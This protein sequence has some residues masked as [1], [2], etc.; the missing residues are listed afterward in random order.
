MKKKPLLAAFLFLIIGASTTW[1]TIS[2][3]IDQVPRAEGGLDKKAAILLSQLLPGAGQTKKREAIAE[4]TKRKDKRF[5]APL[6]D[7]LRYQRIRDDYRLVARALLDLTDIKADR[8]ESFWEQMVIWVAERP[9]LKTPPGYVAWKGKLHAAEIDPR[10]TEFLYEGVEIEKG[11]R[12]EEVVWGGVRVD[13]IPALVNPK[14]LAAEK[15]DYILDSEPV[16]GVSINGDNRAYP[17][18]I[19][20]W[21][22]MA[23]DVVGG[24]QVALA[25]CTLCGAGILFDAELEGGK[26]QFGSSGYLMRSNKLMYD[27][28]TKTL[29]NQLTGKP[30]IGKLVGKNLELKVLPLVLTSWGEWKAQHKNTKVLSLETGYRR[31]YQIGATYGRYFASPNT[32]FPVRKKI[33]KL[34]RK[35]RIY[36]IQSGGLAKAYPLDELNKAGGVVND[37]VGQKNL[38]VVYK[39]AVG[40]VK[41]SDDIRAALK[42][43][44]SSYRFEYANELT[45]DALRRLVKKKPRVVK[46]FTVEMMLAIPTEARLTILNENT[47]DERTGDTAVEGRFTPDFRNQVAQQGLIGETRA[48]ESRS[49]KFRR[50]E[51]PN[52]LLDEKN[53][54]WKITEDALVS[55]EGIK[56]PRVGGHLAF[57]F[58]WVTY[59]SQTEVYKYRN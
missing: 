27:R 2:C 19:L 53:Q 46:A 9:N 40:R 13:G 17:L 32:M 58:G 22:E 44:D 20:D 3:N 57:W 33:G 11:T 50:S 38:V 15:A 34:P 5:I 30:V 51:N 12:V 8:G 56:L 31:P 4:I 41:I 29:W 52:E 14:M 54:I 42:G 35:A 26:L 1:S 49:H 47:T 7:L 39:D 6:V 28:G 18:R 55:S 23:N 10:F 36:A 21:H 37:R 24:R 16:F 43:T 25:Y 45:L 48:F 59:F